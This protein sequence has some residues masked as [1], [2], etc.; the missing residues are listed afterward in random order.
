MKLMDTE[1]FNTMA[2]YLLA[3][4]S[5]IHYG[6]NDFGDLLEVFIE[7]HKREPTIEYTGYRNQGA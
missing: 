7:V 2:D 1:A 6:I 4:E 5:D 3:H